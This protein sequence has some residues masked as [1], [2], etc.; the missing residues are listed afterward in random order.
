MYQKHSSPQPQTLLDTLDLPEELKRAYQMSLADFSKTRQLNPILRNDDELQHIYQDMNHFYQTYVKE[1]P[2]GQRHESDFVID[3]TKQMKEIEQELFQNIVVTRYI[4][5]DSR[6]RDYDQD[7][8][9]SYRV[10]LAHA[11][12]HI[13]RMEL[14]SAEIPRGEY[15][16]NAYNNVIHFQ[17]TTAQVVSNSYYRAIIPQGDY[18]ISQLLSLIQTQ[19]NAVG[20]SSYTITLVNDRVRISSDLTGG[21]GLFRLQFQEHN[22]YLSKT[23]AKVL[24]FK[25]INRSNSAVYT[26]ENGYNTACDAFFFLYLDNI[27]QNTSQNVNFFQKIVMDGNVTFFNQGRTYSLVHEYFPPINLDYLDIRWT[28]RD[29]NP[30]SFQ[31]LSHSLTFKVQMFAE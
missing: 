8:D 6:D 5:L 17:E 12:S 21:D 4:T 25:P 30:I 24:G 1:I 9:D 29:Q 26:A 27:S 3:K 18:T 14:V 2:E 20:Q 28:D 16:I 19:M 23:I 7:S 13:F 15:L 31:G 11:L 10:Y 22:T